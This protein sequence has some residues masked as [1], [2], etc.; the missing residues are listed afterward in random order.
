MTY[1]RPGPLGMHDESVLRVLE[2][3]EDYSRI[4]RL[5]SQT[6]MVYD[7]RRAY[8]T[9]VPGPPLVHA[10][11]DKDAFELDC[12]ESVY[13]VLDRHGRG[14]G[15]RQHRTWARAGKKAVMTRKSVHTRGLE[16]YD[17]I[18]DRT[19]YFGGTSAY[20]EYLAIAT[21]E[22]EA[23]KA[24]LRDQL[25][26]PKSE[27]G[28]HPVTW[29]LAQNCYYAW[30]RKAFEYD[31]TPG[32]KVPA[33]IKAGKSVQLQNA[34]ASVRTKSGEQFKSGGFNARPEK[35]NGKYLLG[36]L[37]L[38]A[39]GRAIDIEADHNPQ[40]DSSIWSAILQYTENSLDQPTRKTLWQSNPKSLYDQIYQINSEFVEKLEQAVAAARKPT[41]SMTPPPADPLAV[42]FAMDSDLRKLK[43]GKVRD[44]WRKWRGGF[45]TLDWNLV[46]ALHGEQF[47]WG[48]VFRDLDLMHFEL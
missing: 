24:I 45:F 19:G 22:L 27:R 7:G 9:N 18:A 41:G 21:A 1:K 10:N 6:N 25:E 46:K 12:L 48:A 35:K 8:C 31:G 39:S 16:Y 28:K 34:L 38:H 37:S 29:K 40:I 47:T 5:S 36:T 15:Y 20:Q 30:V 33:L 14:Y 4:H 44:F 42:A 23:D 32:D 11:R 13:G 26:P 17:Y 43:D 3:A 2:N